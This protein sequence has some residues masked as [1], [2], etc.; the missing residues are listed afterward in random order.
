MNGIKFLIERYNNAYDSGRRSLYFHIITHIALVYFI[1]VGTSFQ[2]LMLVLA[3][4]LYTCFGFSMTFH[5]LLAHRSW[6]APKWFRVVGIFFGTISGVGSALSF[7]STHRDH[8]RYSD[9][10]GDLYSMYN[11]PWWYVQWFAMLERVSLKRAIDLLKDPLCRLSHRH[12]FKIHLAWAAFLFVIDPMAV[13]YFYLAPV[14]L[15]WSAANSLNTLGHWSKTNWI[16]YRN[17]NTN[18]KSVNCLPV[19]IYSCGE[20]WHNN[21][22]YSGRQK[23]FGQKWWEIDISY[24]FIRLIEKK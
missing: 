3:Y 21:H 4:F 17:N 24:L 16:M 8:H 6:V 19:A 11:L 12:F 5:R 7:V 22:H 20:G 10:P 18:D 15:F 9:K 13:I 14:A 2:W 23:N 1:F